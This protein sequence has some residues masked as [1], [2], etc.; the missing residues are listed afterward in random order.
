MSVFIVDSLE[1]VDVYK[2]E[3][4]GPVIS[5]EL[6]ESGLERHV[7]VAPVGNASNSID[8]AE[9]LRFCEATEG[10][11]AFGSLPEDLERTDDSTITI[12]NGGR[13]NIDRNSA[14]V[15]VVQIHNGL[16]VLAI[17]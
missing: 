11:H 13:A 5:L 4:E 9:S 17:V 7:R 2:D 8:Q 10:I 3:C 16:S 1:S 14:P 12:S 15:F 6:Q